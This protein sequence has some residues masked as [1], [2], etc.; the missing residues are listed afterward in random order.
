MLFGDLHLFGN[1][2]AQLLDELHKE[3]ELFIGYF[4]GYFLHALLFLKYALQLGFGNERI[5][6]S[7]DHFF[8]FLGKAVDLLQPV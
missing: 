5:Q 7:I 4:K 8:V 2:K 6:E 1:F 3:A